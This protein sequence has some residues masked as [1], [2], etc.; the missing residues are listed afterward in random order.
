MNFYNR[1]LRDSEGGDGGSDGDNNEDPENNKNTG[2]VTMTDSELKEIRNRSYRNG[3][4]DAENRLAQKYLG[5]LEE[6][7]IKSIDGD[8]EKS[9][10]AAGESLKT[11]GKEESEKLQLAGVGG[12][13]ITIDVVYADRPNESSTNQTSQE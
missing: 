6:L 13:K 9:I 7:G 11:S 10:R 1:L 2:K 3:K 5:V 4:K 12:R 8:V